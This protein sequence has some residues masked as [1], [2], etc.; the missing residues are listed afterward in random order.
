MGPKKDAKKGGATFE[1]DPA[2]YQRPP[3]DYPAAAEDVAALQPLLKNTLLK[4]SDVLPAWDITDVKWAESVEA[5]NADVAITY[6]AHIQVIEKKPLRVYLKLEANEPVIVDPKA[7]GKKPDAK[8]GAVEEGLTEPAIDAETG[9]TLPRMFLESVDVQNN[10]IEPAGFNAARPFKSRLDTAQKIRKAEFDR[11]SAEITAANSAAAAAPDGNE[12]GQ[13][14]FLEKRAV[15]LAK[16]HAEALKANDVGDEAPRGGVVDALMTAAFDIVSRMG[17]Q[18]MAG[19]D[20]AAPADGMQ[21]LWRSIYPKLPNSNRPCYNPAG[22]YF[23]RLYLGGAWRMVLVTDEVPLDADGDCVVACSSNP[24]E[25]WPMILAKAVYAAYGKCGYN[26]SLGA[27]LDDSVHGSCTRSAAF[28]TAFAVHVL[29]GWQ[30]GSPL[31]LGACLSND[32]PRTRTLREEIIFGGASLIEHALIPASLEKLL[33]SENKNKQKKESS[34]SDGGGDNAAAELTSSL[35]GLRTKK[36]FKEDY[37]RKQSEREA[38]INILRQRESLIANIESAIRNPFTEVF[39]VCY[40]DGEGSLRIAPILA[41]SYAKVEGDA[42]AAAEEELGQTR[43]LVGWQVVKKAPFVEP[44]VDVSKLSA[45]EQYNATLPKLPVPT[46]VRMDWVSLSELQSGNA[47]I[48]AH[49]T[50]LRTPNAAAL[51][52]NWIADEPEEAVGDKGK[53]KDK[54]GKDAAPV[55]PTGGPTMCVEAGQLEPTLLKVDNAA[56]FMSAPAAGEVVSAGGDDEAA[57]ALAA[58]ADEL[59]RVSSSMMVPLAPSLS[60]SIMIHADMSAQEKP[61]EGADVTAMAVA[62]QKLPSGVVVVLQEVRTDDLD[63]LVMRV[64]LGQDAFVPMTRVTFHVPAERLSPSAKEPLL[65]WVRLYTQASVSMSFR[66]GVNVVVGAAET[67]WASCG[68]DYKSLVKTGKAPSTAANTEQVLFRLPLQLAGRTENVFTEK[69][70]VCVHV[71]DATLA[72]HISAGLFS[73]Q[74]ILPYDPE[75]APANAEDDVEIEKVAVNFADSQFLPRLAPIF[76][77]LSNH[78]TTTLLARCQLNRFLHEKLTGKKDLTDIPGFSWKTVVLTKR[79]EVLPPANLQ[80]NNKPARYIGAYYPN[81]NLTMFRDVIAFEK[82]SF[83]LSLS[84]SVR[85]SADKTA[86]A[87]AAAEPSDE[88][89]SEKP[90]ERRAE[91]IR[92]YGKSS[93][94]EPPAMPA[95]H[96]REFCEQVPLRLRLYRKSDA[97]LVYECRGSGSVS[98]HNVVIHSFLGKGE[99]APTRSADEAPPADSKGAKKDDKKGKGAPAGSGDDIEV[100]TELSIDES[101]MNI[102]AVWRSRLPYIFH[103]GAEGLNSADPNAVQV[104]VDAQVSAAKLALTEGEDPGSAAFAN[105]APVHPQFLWS[106]DILCGTVTAAQHDYSDVEK[107]MKLKQSWADL[108]PSRDEYQLESSHFFNKTAALQASKHEGKS[109]PEYFTPEIIEHLEKAIY[110]KEPGVGKK[111]LETVYPA[112]RNPFK[113]NISGSGEP[114]FFQSHADSTAIRKNRVTES[115]NQGQAAKLGLEKLMAFNEQMREQ[116]LVRIN[117]L[118]NAA[119]DA[120]HP[121]APE[122]GAAARPPASTILEWWN[123]REKY[124]ND[125]D[126]L[127]ESLSVVLGRASTAIESSLVAEGGGDPKKKKK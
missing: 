84:F 110:S 78:G 68:S 5:D 115:A 94:E 12:E 87:V 43:L 35:G 26:G 3:T 38:I 97:V 125:T 33:V 56:F 114:R 61:V 20:E 27:P 41:I 6:P 83:P 91:A 120:E 16:S 54:K 103:A 69:A 7:K 64:E 25:L 11:L 8:K 19:K 75:S 74:Q 76:T 70:L 73:A 59:S 22:K 90:V 92:T 81:R 36:Q 65:F 111:R 102:P 98:L 48:V 14:G 18:V 99:S 23:V 50:L 37:M 122:V 24:L 62:Q 89:K 2:V 67:V 52:W 85:P 57:A 31:E 10:P 21:Y 15:A 28:F 124:R 119:Y 105:I 80:T 63:P 42:D 106:Y 9:K 1:I 60:L 77:T 82:A 47:H 101:A 104:I 100:I 34:T 30:P 45:V 44:Y 72:Q 96:T 88:E 107:L 71:P 117:E 55:G 40:R 4:V 53:G 127:N 32:V 116:T 17:P 39:T 93:E 51:P 121:H 58:Q 118:V 113:E 79:S 112:G 95:V 46:E 108:M 86:A 66:C 13:K 123:M 126:K 49:D 109:E 29:T